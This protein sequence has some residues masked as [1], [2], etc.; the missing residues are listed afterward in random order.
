MGATIYQL[1]GMG[2]E[3]EASI[4]AQVVVGVAVDSTSILR[5]KGLEFEGKRL[6][7]LLEALA[8]PSIKRARYTW[9]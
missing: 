7:V 5:S 3:L 9:G 2:E 4:A 1:L 6:L 8:G